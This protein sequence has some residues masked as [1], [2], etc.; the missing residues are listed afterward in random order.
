MF[1]MN[2]IFG[3]NKKDPKERVRELQRK[4]RHEIN[5][6]KRQINRMDMEEEKVKRQIKDAAKKGHKDVCLVLAKSLVQSRKTKNRMHMSCTQ[7]NSILM[8]MQHQV[9]TIRM[10]GAIQQSSEVMKTMQ[11]LIKV[12]EIMQTMR[13]MS[14]EL[15]AAGI[16]EEMI[17]DT[18]EASKSWNQKN[19]KNKLRQLRFREEIEKVLYEVT[20]GEIG[21]APS[22]IR[23][24]LGTSAQNARVNAEAEELISKLQ[25]MPH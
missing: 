16:M 6:I 17:E 18:F 21:K 22:A 8:H 14:K 15:T 2:G 25:S 11:Q 13:E 12:P 24:D 9:S 4:L 10:A 20:A 7:I 19:S 5:G 23:D 1:I 3:Q